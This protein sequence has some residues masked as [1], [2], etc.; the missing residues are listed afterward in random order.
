MQTRFAAFRKLVGLLTSSEF[1]ATVHSS[2][3]PLGSAPRQLILFPAKYLQVWPSL[4]PSLNRELVSHIFHFSPEVLGSVEDYCGLLV[5]ALSGRD[6]GSSQQAPL[7]Q[8]LTR[9]GL[10][11]MLCAP[12]GRAGPHSC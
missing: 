11:N 7:C 10:L 2:P 5:Q 12:L 6:A 1:Y 3:L 4:L 9:C 8:T